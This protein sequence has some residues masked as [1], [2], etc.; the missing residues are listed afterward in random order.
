MFIGGPTMT[1]TRVLCLM[2]LVVCSAVA[3]VGQIDP[4]FSSNWANF[5]STSKPLE[6]PTPQVPDLVCFGS[7]PNW[8]FQFGQ[9]AARALDV[10]GGDKYWTGKFTYVDGKWSWHGT[11]S[12][13]PGAA[14][15]ATMTKR[16]GVNKTQADFK[17]FPYQGQISR[18]EGDIVSGG[19][20]KLKRG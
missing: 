1:G 17:D 5:P 19:C 2:V 15:A 14:L 18:P 9:Q 11:L 16:K 20:R 4:P 12:P 7:N 3:A 10:S 13:G 6:K 8:S